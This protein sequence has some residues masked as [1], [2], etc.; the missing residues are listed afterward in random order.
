MDITR[1]V[2]EVSGDIT[3]D[4][5]AV[6]VAALMIHLLDYPH[7]S[8]YRYLVTDRGRLHYRA[9]LLGAGMNGIFDVFLKHRVEFVAVHYPFAGKP[10]DKSAVLRPA[11]MVDIY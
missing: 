2:S 10:H 7:S 8:G 6:H 3:L 11:D 9:E 5:S 4:K 1:T